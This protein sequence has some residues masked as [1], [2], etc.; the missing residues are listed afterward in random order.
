M[1][2]ALH[3]FEAPSKHNLNNVSKLILCKKASHSKTLKKFEFVYNS[4]VLRTIVPFLGSPGFQQ[5][6]ASPMMPLKLQF[7]FDFFSFIGL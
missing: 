5:D 4:V 2:S 1:Q 7:G 3:F 6:Q